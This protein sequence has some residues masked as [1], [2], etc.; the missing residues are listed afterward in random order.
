MGDRKK[1]NA[2]SMDERYANLSLVA[3]TRSIIS[4]GISIF[5]QA[6]PDN[7]ANTKTLHAQTYNIMVLCSEDY[8]VE[9]GARKG[10]ILFY[11]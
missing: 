6:T 8:I 3:K 4:L 9:P 2:A 7:H 1:L 5:K 11:S 10:E